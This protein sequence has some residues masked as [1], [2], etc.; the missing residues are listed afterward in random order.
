MK[1]IALVGVTILALSTAAALG[2]T[3]LYLYT[4]RRYRWRLA[5][6]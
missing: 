4:V 2:P 5:Q 3:P 1:R 6:M